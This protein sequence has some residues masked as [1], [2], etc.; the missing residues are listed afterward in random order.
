MD[1]NW[2]REIKGF[3]GKGRFVQGTKK[4]FEWRLTAY[5]LKYLFNGMDQ[6]HRL[7]KFE[8]NMFKRFFSGINRRLPWHKVRVKLSK[9]EAEWLDKSRFFNPTQ[10]FFDK[11]PDFKMEVLNSDT[12]KTTF[13]IYRC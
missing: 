13:Q 1:K 11:R 3:T 5:E 12:E 8:P 7:N 2:K 4:G 6:G 10:S 9:C